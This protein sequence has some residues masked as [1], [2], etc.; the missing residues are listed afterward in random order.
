MAISVLVPVLFQATI[1]TFIFAAETLGEKNINL[2]IT[3]TI[4]GCLDI[5]LIDTMKDLLVNFAG[6]LAFSIVGYRYLKGNESGN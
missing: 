6:A 2:S 3:A 5:G 1:Y 4:N